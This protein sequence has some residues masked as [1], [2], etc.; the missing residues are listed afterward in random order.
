MIYIADAFEKWQH[1]AV[2]MENFRWTWQYEVLDTFSS[3]ITSGPEWDDIE[4]SSPVGMCVCARLYVCLH[5]IQSAYM[6]ARCSADVIQ[7]KVTTQMRHTG[8]AAN[9]SQYIVSTNWFFIILQ[10][11]M[12]PHRL[13]IW[14]CIFTIIFNADNS[15]LFSF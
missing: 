13:L 2:S 7:V 1:Y 5:R 15:F 9:S 11:E 10:L 6:S 4:N 3:D 12:L 14:Q 8:L